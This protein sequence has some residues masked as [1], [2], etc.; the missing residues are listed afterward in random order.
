ML[1]CILAGMLVMPALAAAPVA[2]P[3]RFVGVNVDG[4]MN[5][6]ASAGMNLSQ[7]FGLMEQTGVESVR[8]VFDWSFAQ[9]YASWSDVPANARSQYTDAGGVPT[10]FS[11]EDQIVA[12]A[13]KRGLTVLPVVIYPPRWDF[14]PAKVLWFGRPE[15]N[16]P[17]A[18]FL[19]DLI[20]RYGPNGSFWNGRSGPRV[21][22]RQWQIW[23]EPDLR[24]FWPTQP[25]ASTY[26][27]LLKAAHS[28]IKKADPGAQVVLAGLVN[29]S[30]KDLETIYRV[31]GARAAFDVAAAHP[32]TAKPPGVITILRNVRQVMDQNGDSGKPMI[33]DEVSWISAQGQTRGSGDASLGIS[34]TEAGQAHNIA[35]LLPLLARDRRSLGLTSFYYYTWAGNAMRSGSI[36]SIATIFSFGGLLKYGNGKFTEKPAFFAFEKAA[37][38]MEHCKRK[39]TLA[40]HCARTS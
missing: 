19:T 22:I 12:L 27:A 28:A 35:A 18:A 16:G 37:L 7:Q 23:N 21:P 13:A 31:A 4:P 33:A 5:P 20:D 8:V 39:G 1:A 15:R 10:N 40:T 24:G 25:F 3:S 29:Y 6:G 11:Q 26:V 2:V 17:Y 14:A 38:A 34:T 36:F 30:W 9:P 32:F